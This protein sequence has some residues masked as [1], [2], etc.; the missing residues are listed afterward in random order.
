MEIK[1]DQVSRFTTIH[2]HTVYLLTELDLLIIINV[3][4][5]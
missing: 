5:K 1:L 3:I 4:C 2:I